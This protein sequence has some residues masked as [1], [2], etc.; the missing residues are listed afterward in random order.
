[1]K[2]FLR[3]IVKKG[4]GAFA[5]L[6]AHETRDWESPN[7]V[8]AAQGIMASTSWREAGAPLRLDEKEFRVFSQWGD[9]GIIQFLVQVL[10]LKTDSF[11]E[12]GVADFYESNTHFLLINNNWR[13]FVIDGSADNIRV[14]KNSSLYWR[15]DLQAEASFVT[16]DNINQLLGK[17]GFKKIGLL[18]IDLDGNDYWI[19]KALDLEVYQPDILIL[20]YNAHFGAERALSIPYDQQFYRMNAHYSGQYFGASLAALNLIAVEKGYYFIGCNSA[21]NNAYFLHNSHRGVIPPISLQDGFVDAR[22]RD[23]RD[24]Q[25][26]LIYCS[27]ESAKESI[28]GLPVVNVKDGQTEPF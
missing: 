22:F 24:Q 28:R 17:S 21:G 15:Y 4:G 27:R 5:R 25:G 7:L 14:V 3:K 9:D 23:S 12:F 16:L 20:E 19:L 2:Q 26:N 11:I 8:L 18:H 1:V 6:V 13:G 10:Q